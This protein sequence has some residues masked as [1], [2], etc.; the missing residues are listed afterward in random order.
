MPAKMPRT[1]AQAAAWNKFANAKTRTRRDRERFGRFQVLD[2]RTEIN[3][4]RINRLVLRDLCSVQHF[5]SIAFEHF[6]AAPTLECNDLA[7]NAL[8]ARTIEVTQISTH[9][10]ARR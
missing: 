5:E 4:L 8:F 9:Q 2:H 6:L 10:G 3:R 1:L 7:I